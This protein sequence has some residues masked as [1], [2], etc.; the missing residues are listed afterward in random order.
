MVSLMVALPGPAAA[1]LT[2]TVPVYGRLAGTANIAGF[3]AAYHLHGLLSV[4]GVSAA[5]ASGPAA[6]LAL[7]ALGVL[8]LCALGF[9]CLRE[10]LLPAPGVA[11]GDS[12]R[13][14]GPTPRARS[15]PRSFLDGFATN[16]LNPKVAMFYLA[17]FPQFLGTDAVAHAAAL[18]LVALHCLASVLWFGALVLVLD[19]LASSVGAPAWERRVKGATGVAFVG[20]GAMLVGVGA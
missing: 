16:A 19:R 12:T 18:V 9:L 13:T 20:F 15:I 14:R 17:A 6:F 4:L 3:V 5:L 1:L 8:Y 10:A 7:K 2:R 11:K